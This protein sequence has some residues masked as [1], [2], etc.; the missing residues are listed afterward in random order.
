MKLLKEQSNNLSVLYVE[1]DPGI[2]NILKELLENFFSLLDFAIDGQE[3]LEKYKARYKESGSYYDIILTDINMPNMNGIEMSKKIRKINSEQIILV[4]SA[5]NDSKNLLELINLNIDYFISKPIRSEQILEVLFK[6]CSRINDKF[7]LEHY[8]KTIETLHEELNAKNIQLEKT[9]KFYKDE[10]EILSK[11]QVIDTNSQAE[12]TNSTLKKE[13]ISISQDRQKDIRFTRYDHVSA[14]SFLSTLD[15]SM[16]DK[17]EE[18]VHELDRLT[19]IIYDIDDM[20]CID[21]QNNLNEMVKILNNFTQ[22][23][24]S[25]I[26]FPVTVRAFQSLTDFLTTIDMHK[27]EDPSKK[28]LFIEVFLGVS[29]DL[30]EWIDSIFIAKNADNIHYFDASFT[31][32]CLEIESMFSEQEIE[33]D[34]DDLEFF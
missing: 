24:D 11:P 23:V 9:I 26:A 20:K 28:K 8:Y 29:K 12:N 31:N 19:V 27:N 7:L 33:S 6:T 5:E 25:L 3:A 22:I 15:D 2:L 34:D 10:V 32:N 18:F 1:D 17:I 30:E 21:S 4:I 14:I 13:T 16:I